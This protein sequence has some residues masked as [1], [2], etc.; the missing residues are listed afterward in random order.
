MR[1][2]SRDDCLWLVLH[3]MHY[4]FMLT[5]QCQSLCKS[6]RCLIMITWYVY[7]PHSW[8]VG[9]EPHY[10]IALRVCHESVPTHRHVWELGVVVRVIEASICFRSPHDLEVMPM[11]MEWMLAGIVVVQDDLYDLALLKDEGVGVAAVYRGI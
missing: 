6:Q 4:I 10:K 11:Q 3:T 1:D 2:A 9:P 8:V 5:H 7:I